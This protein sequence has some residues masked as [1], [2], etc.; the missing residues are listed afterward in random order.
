MRLHSFINKLRT[1]LNFLIYFRQ[2]NFPKDTKMEQSDGTFN[3]CKPIEVKT[4]AETS[5]QKLP[6]NNPFSTQNEKNPVAN[7]IKREAGEVVAVD[8]EPENVERKL[9]RNDKFK[10]VASMFDQISAQFLSSCIVKNDLKDPESYDFQLDAEHSQNIRPWIKLDTAIK[11]NSATNTWIFM[12]SIPL[13]AS[14]KMRVWFEKQKLQA[15]TKNNKYFCM[16]LSSFGENNVKKFLKALLSGEFDKL[17]VARGHCDPNMKRLVQNFNVGYLN[18]RFQEE[19]GFTV[20]RNHNHHR[21]NGGNRDRNNG[22][23][24][25]GRFNRR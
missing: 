9:P 16:D 1:Y 20:N 18:K 22:R 8:K 23:N 3:F 5:Q 7:S 19:T 2:I 10:V 15:N 21:N 13:Q 4:E 17:S 24:N 11:L 14:H 6:S 25:N 12:S